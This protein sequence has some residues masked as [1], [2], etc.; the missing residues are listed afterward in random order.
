MNST[1]HINLFWS[2]EEQAWV[3]DIPDLEPCTTFGSTRAEAL[4]K[5][6][7]LI[8][9]WL[10]SARANGDPIPE[11]RYRPAIYAFRAA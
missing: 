4:S 11:P 10:E 1:Y 8:D 2:D 6:E 5:A 3:A 7:E 9:L